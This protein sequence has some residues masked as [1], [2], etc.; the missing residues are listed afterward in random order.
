MAINTKNRKDLK[1]YFIKNAIP[2]EGNFA[3]FV[4]AQLNQA[5]DGV[6]KLPNEPLSVVAASGEQRRA[7]RLY[8]AYPA[9]NPDWLISLNPAQDPANAASTRPGFGITDAAGNTRLF[10]EPGTGNLGVGTNEPKKRLHVQGVSSGPFM[11]DQHDRPGIVVTGSYPEIGL[12]SNADNGNHGPAI[13]L[14]AYTDASATTF[15]QWV[16]GTAGRNASFL[17]IGFSDKSDPNPHAGI[18]NYHG[19]TVLTLTADG[20]VGIG[21][22]NPLSTLTVGGAN[23]SLRISSGNDNGYVFDNDNADGFKLKLRYKNPTNVVSE[24]MTFNYANGNVGIG[25]TDPQGMLDV[26]LA[27]AGAWNRFVV[28]TTAAWG[29]GNAQYVTI[30]AG[31]AAGIMFW[32]PHVPWYAPEQ[33]ASIR[34]GRATGS[35]GD[36]WWD[37]G[38]RADGGFSFAASDNGAAGGDLLKVSKAGNVKVGNRFTAGGYFETGAGNV[39]SYSLEVGGPTPNPTSGHATIFLHHHGVV[40]HQLRYTSGTLFLEKAG[41]G[42]GTHGVP[43]LDVG[44]SIIFGGTCLKSSL[45][46]KEDVRP[47]TECL[48][49]VQRLWP[50][51]YALRD[52]PTSGSDT[53]GLIAEDVRAV[54]PVLVFEDER[55]TGGFFA[56]GLRPDSLAALTI[57]ALKELSRKVARLERKVHGRLPVGDMRTH[58]DSVEVLSEETIPGAHGVDESYVAVRFTGH[59]DDLGPCD[60]VRYFRLPTDVERGEFLRRELTHWRG[61]TSALEE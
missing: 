37:A 34:Y 22:T 58:E 56:A 24:I 20:M 30:G 36:T 10:I 7:L 42:Y 9:A 44:G 29:D 60:I 57:G 51:R 59:D 27:G 15:K 32:N 4:D 16:L 17:D 1:S 8:A 18:R 13:R 41:N 39:N 28:T 3:D 33:R 49:M 35:T 52:H 25:T 61:R 45:R 40:A 43:N 53:F 5:D 2:T 55:E 54:E 38:V 46:Y 14:G 48:D 31:G 11:N 47:L 50:V 6:F 23:A 21:W 26:R 12:F 19:K